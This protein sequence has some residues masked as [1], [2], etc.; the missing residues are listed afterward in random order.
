MVPIEK[1]H[2]QLHEPCNVARDWSTRT[3]IVHVLGYDPGPDRARRPD[4]MPLLGIEIETLC[5]S[6]G[7]HKNQ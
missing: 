7:L 4:G 5:C 3:R 1:Q 6:L 2:S